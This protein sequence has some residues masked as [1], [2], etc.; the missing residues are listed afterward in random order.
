[1][2]T[3]VFVCPSGSETIATALGQGTPRCATGQGTW[4]EVG[5]L[6][7]ENLPPP[8]KTMTEDGQVMYW[9]GLAICYALGFMGGQQR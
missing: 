9:V 2:A 3:L 8:D 5:L 4:V 1:M 6:I 7:E